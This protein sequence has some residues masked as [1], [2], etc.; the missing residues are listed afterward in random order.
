MRVELTVLGAYGRYGM[1]SCADSTCASTTLVGKEVVLAYGVSL[2]G[3]S[4]IEFMSNGEP[5]LNNGDTYSMTVDGSTKSIK[6]A[7]VTGHVTV[8]P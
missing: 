2:T 6:I 1:Y 7:A 4:T 8:T 3:P 5:V